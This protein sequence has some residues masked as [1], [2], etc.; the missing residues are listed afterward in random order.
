MPI[1]L[2]W[3]DNNCLY[4]RIHRLIYSNVFNCN[5]LH[6]FATSINIR[7]IRKKVGMVQSCNDENWRF[8]LPEIHIDA[9]L[10]QQ[11]LET[12]INGA[13]IIKLTKKTRDLPYCVLKKCLFYL[14]TFG[15]VSYQGEKKI[16]KLTSNGFEI[17]LMIN[18]SH[19]NPNCNNE[20]IVIYN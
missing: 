13:T 16:Y 10:V 5:L 19:R 8:V 20:D 18:D 11:I 2:C 1:L 6:L 3:I 12:C 9:N 15:L 4:R 14:I 17:L 7:G